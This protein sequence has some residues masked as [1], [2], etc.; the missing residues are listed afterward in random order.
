MY[1]SIRCPSG[2]LRAAA[3]AFFPPSAPND[4]D[5]A[6][7]CRSAYPPRRDVR[8]AERESSR[9]AWLRSCMGAVEKRWRSSSM[10]AILQRW[11]H[12]ELFAGASTSILCTRSHGTR[13]SPMVRQLTRVAELPATPYAP[14]GDSRTETATVREQG[15]TGAGGERGQARRGELNVSSDVDLVRLHGR[16][17]T[18]ATKRFETRVLRT[19]QGRHRALTDTAMASISCRHAAPPDGASGQLA[20]SHAGGAVYRHA[21]RALSA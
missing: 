2:A 12:F 13:A 9:E 15:E 11:R 20:V 1:G 21:G 6:A 7:L 17:N 10:P 16:R 14:H 4:I 19:L 8:P 5:I 18:T 3:P